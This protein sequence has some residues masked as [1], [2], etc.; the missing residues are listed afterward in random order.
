MQGTVLHH[1][2]CISCGKE[3]DTYDKKKRYCSKGCY[4]VLKICENCGKEFRTTF[5]NQPYCSR[6][7]GAAHKITK[8]EKTC[9]ICGKKYV[10]QAR[11]D[12][13]TKTC[14]RECAAVWQSQRTT[15][16]RRSEYV[17]LHC[18]YCGKPFEMRKKAAVNKINYCSKECLH[19]DVQYMVKTC[20]K[21]GKEFKTYA[22]NQ[23]HCS[24]ACRRNRVHKICPICGKEFEV[25]NVNQE[26][27]K[28]CSYECSNKALS[29]K[30]KGKKRLE[31]QGV[32]CSYCG[33]LIARPPSMLNGKKNVYCNEQCMGK[34]KS[35]I[36]VGENN[37]NWNNGASFEP[38]CKKWTKDTRTR[39]RAFF[40][41]VCFICGL[42]T[43][44]H[45][46]RHGNHHNLTVHHVHYDKQICCNGRP[47][48]MVPLCRSHNSKVNSNKEWWIQYFENIL[49][50]EP[51]NGKTYFTKD[52]YQEAIKN[53]L[54][55]PEIPKYK[56]TNKSKI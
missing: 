39:V 38:Y 1:L 47:E 16:Q 4:G 37:P 27:R 20:I 13:K 25:A 28:H 50:K 22:P 51:W 42:P 29:L 5:I 15:G 31:Y 9:M 53:G 14:S 52:E 35:I 44:E 45:L 55:L 56:G 23:I 46:D 41:D 2:K 32:L 7:C 49:Y 34:H 24:M 30:T 17:T 10:V 36:N 8:V 40:G 43:E 48:I 6:K 21:C 11:F 19:K 54:K 26:R 33:K 3:Y 18:K 12:K